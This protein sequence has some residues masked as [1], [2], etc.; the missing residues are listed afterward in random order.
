[1]KAALILVSLLVL[2]SPG[3]AKQK[4]A[5]IVNK[6][7]PVTSLTED[8]IRDL[9]LGE[10]PF[11]HD[12]ERALPSDQ[13]KDA[14]ITEEFYDSLAHMTVKEISVHWAKKIFTGRGSPPTQISGGD[15]RVKDWVRADPRRLGYIYASSADNS[16]RTIF[17]LDP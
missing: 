15:Q 14:A 2:A 4:I 5:V 9:F 1:M 8:Q 11:L 13:P 6:D 10:S 17:V 12:N 3:W 16:V 7:A